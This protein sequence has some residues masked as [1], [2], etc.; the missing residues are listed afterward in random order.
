MV[1]MKDETHYGMA[2]QTIIGQKSIQ[3]VADT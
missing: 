2:V 1:E 3:M